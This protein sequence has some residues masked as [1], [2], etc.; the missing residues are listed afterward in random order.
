M[1]YIEHYIQVEERKPKLW[2][3]P[4]DLA[5][6]T[7]GLSLHAIRQLLAQAAYSDQP[8]T[9]VDLVSKVESFIQSQVGEDVVEFKKPTHTLDARGRIPQAQ[10]VH[11]ARS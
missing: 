6:L 10:G 7:A 1:A 11:R 2:S 5:A 8:L 3:T 9:P 4:D